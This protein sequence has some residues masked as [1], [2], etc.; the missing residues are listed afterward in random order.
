MQI[1]TALIQG[2]NCTLYLFLTTV[3][4]IQNISEYVNAHP[5]TGGTTSQDNLQGKMKVNNFDLKKSPKEFHFN[6]KNLDNRGIMPL[7]LI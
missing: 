7:G 4:D 1:H 2:N 5:S 6:W 3:F